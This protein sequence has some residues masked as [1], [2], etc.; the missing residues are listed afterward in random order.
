[1]KGKP[2]RFEPLVDVEKLSEFLGGI[3]KKTIYKWTSESKIN[4]FPYYRPGRGLRFR[5][6]EVDAW[7]KKYR[8]AGGLNF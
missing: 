3:P 4:G 7:L 6:S 5:I 1:M 2:S 8:S